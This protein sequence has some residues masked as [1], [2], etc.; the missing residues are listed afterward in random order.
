MSDLVF[1]KEL[2]QQ[3]LGSSEEFPV[4]FDDAYQWLEYSTK[5]N[6][7]RSFEN[8]GFIKGIDFEVFIVNDKNP[9]GGRPTEQIRLSVDCL[10]QWGMLSGTEK[11]KT[12]R[13]YFLECE[14]VAKS[15]TQWH[16]ELLDALKTMQQQVSFLTERTNRLDAAESLLSNVK[17]AALKHRGCGRIIYSELSDEKSSDELLTAGEYLLEKEAPRIFLRTLAKRTAQFMGTGLGKKLTQKRKGRL[18]FE[19]RYLDQVFDSLFN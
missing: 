10:K 15:I 7:K 16:P 2:A 12:I 8:A 3:L 19:R 13:R 1:T 6:A 14:K 4:D 17:D 18:L 9:L 5:G 11:G